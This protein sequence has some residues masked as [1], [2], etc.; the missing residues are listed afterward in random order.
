MYLSHI[1]TFRALAIL[2]IVAGHAA[3]SVS[4]RDH[5]LTRDAILDLMEN[6]TVLFVFVSGYL[7]QT[8][9]A[10]YRYAD[11]LGK[12][13]KN[14]L[15]PYLVVSIPAVVHAVFWNDA[16][17]RYS[18]LEGATPL[19]QVVWFYL[20]GG[21]HLNYPL[22]FIPLIFVYFLL[23]PLFMLVI[24]K[25]AW[26]ASLLVLIPLSLLAHRPSF[27]NP[28]LSHSVVYFLSAYVLGMFASQYREWVD[29]FLER[30]LP[31]LTS[32]LVAFFL[33]HL[34]GSDNHGNYRVGAMFSF[35]K[36]YVD[37]LY[38][39]KL[40]LAFLLLGLARQHDTRLGRPLHYL[41]QASFGIYLL[42]AYF[43]N[44]FEA[45]LGAKSA[46]G[47]LLMWIVL[48]VLAILAC[49]ATIKLTQR[50]LGRYSRYAIGS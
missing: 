4:W 43:L 24:R 27:P 37:W 48:C 17:V 42:H 33:I 22:W 18:V 28:D 36:G 5:P 10:K 38:L 7:F 14:V 9:S 21:A 32:G 41:G 13:I 2:F 34:F 50:L 11:Y 26:Y 49:V 8:L 16:T 15:I 31:L 25:P 39:Q 45:L 40:L 12:K 20:Q 3:A 23:S 19:H 1:N 46:T 47:P 6:G 44:A 29:A 35:E 30:H